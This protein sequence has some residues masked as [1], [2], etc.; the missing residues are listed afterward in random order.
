MK[1]KL[2]SILAPILTGVLLVSAGWGPIGHSQIADE[3]IYGDKV[4]ITDAEAFRA[5]S[6]LPD[7]ALVSGGT[8]VEHGWLH[9]EVFI[10]V[11]WSLADTP[12]KQDCVK[13]YITHI[14]GDTVEEPWSAQQTAAGAPFKA[15]FAADALMLSVPGYDKPTLNMTPELRYF[16]SS[17]WRQSHPPGTTWWLSNTLLVWFIEPSFNG[18]FQLGYNSIFHPPIDE[19]QQWYGA[20]NTY[21]GESVNRATARLNGAPTPIPSPVPT[22]R[23]TPTPISCP[24]FT[25]C[26]WR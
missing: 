17:A 22:P 21:T 23:P 3:I 9:S 10:S 26:Y 4:E 7:M 15:D 13:G 6:L 12:E 25:R 14:E 11:L 16:L 1:T 2:A 20:Y 24:K 18:Y 19:A 8:W 5:C